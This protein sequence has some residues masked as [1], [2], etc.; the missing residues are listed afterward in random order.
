MPVKGIY[1][2]FKLFE[3]IANPAEYLFRKKNRFHTQLGFTTRPNPIHFEVPLPLYPVFKEIFLEDVYDIH[4]LLPKLG[5]APIVIDVGANA[6]YFDYLLLSKKKNAKIYAFEPLPGNVA[7]ISKTKKANTILQDQLL[8]TE[9]AVTGSSIDPLI[10]FVET[11]NESVVASMHDNFD[12]RNKEKIVVETIPFRNIFDTH[13]LKLVDLLKMDCE[14]SEYDIFY[15]TPLEYLQRIK[16]I[17]LEVHDLN[18]TDHQIKAIT[19]FLIE[20]NFSVQS[21]PINGFC[22]ALTAY[23]K[24]YFG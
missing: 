5:Y 12:A 23:N 6:G 15:N 13:K 21:V 3:N 4:L 14:G 17:S 2:Y 20:A 22:H 11:A 18:D 19:Q 9:K 16:I 8:I 10:L 1:R 24:S 7:Q